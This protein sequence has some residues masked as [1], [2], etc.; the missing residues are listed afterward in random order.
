MSE[1]TIVYIMQWCP[2][3][4]LVFHSIPSIALGAGWVE[5]IFSNSLLSRT[6]WGWETLHLKQAFQA[7]GQGQEEGLPASLSNFTPFFSLLLH[8]RSLPFPFLPLLLLLAPCPSFSPT[9]LLTKYV[10]IIMVGWRQ[11]PPHSANL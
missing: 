9:M 6:F 3:T 1:H 8:L 7:V 4:C 2:I 10:Y 5:G 11:I